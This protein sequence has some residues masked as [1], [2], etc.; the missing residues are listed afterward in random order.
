MAQRSGGR[1]HRFGVVAP[2]GRLAL[3]LP[4]LLAPADAF[5]HASDRGYVLLLPTGH[6]LVGGALAVAA[7]FLALPLFPQAPL[8]RLATWRLRLFLVP[9]QLRFWTSLTAFAVMVALVV[10]GVL[11]SRD[12]LSNPLPLVVWTLLWIGLTLLQGVFGDIWAWLDPWYA[13]VRIAG[14]ILPKPI[15][16]PHWLGYRPA[17]ILFAGFAWFELIDRA[18]DDPYRLAVAVAGYWGFSFAMMLVF[19]HEDWRR[20]GEFLSVF[21]RLVSR[22]GIFEA[23]LD[24]GDG[25]MRLSLCLPAAKLWS[26]L[27]LPLSGTLFL[28]F[29]LGSVSFDG[30]SKTFLWLGANGIN[31][32]EFPGRSAMTVITGAGLLLFSAGLAAVFLACVW[33]GEKLAGRNDTVAAAGRL[34]WSIVPI[35]LAYHFSH[36]LVALLVNGQY[37]LVAL[38]D[39]FDLGWNLFGTAHMTVSAGIAAGSA[40]AWTIWNLQAFAII[41]GHVLAVVVAHALAGRPGHSRRTP[42]SELPLTLLMIAYTVFGLWLLSTP[43]GA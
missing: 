8:R 21:F 9:T 3:M 27:A 38:S 35:A 17:L 2:T 18:P 1:V 26:E 36:Y 6:Y 23:M 30:L 20:H 13:P 41:G 4:L 7:S 39:P 22:F 28:L 12:P 42:L 19:G 25:R 40:A 37:A 29:A 16:Y 33:L 15:A 34:V 32:L 5:A 31:P 14:R 11:G 43:T 24:A 10:A